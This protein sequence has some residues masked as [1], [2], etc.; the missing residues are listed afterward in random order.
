MKNKPFF[1]KIILT[2]SCIV[3]FLLM[4]LVSFVMLRTKL[5]ES[6]RLRNLQV[7]NF[8][9]NMEQWEKEF[10]NL[11]NMA[12]SIRILPSFDRFAL[13]HSDDYF[14][15]LTNLYTEFNRFNRIITSANY[16]VFVHK[17]NDNT[18]ITNNGTR[19]LEMVLRDL[20]LS[21]GSYEE[22]IK[23][24]TSERLYQ[25]S[26]FISDHTLL[27]VYVV[28][29]IDTQM[30]ISIHIPMSKISEGSSLTEPE[31]ELVINDPK[32]IDLREEKSPK[33]K[34]SDLNS[35]QI[36]IHKPIIQKIDG[37]EYA[38]AASSYINLYYIM[39]LHM[40][41]LEEGI[42][43]ILQIAFAFIVICGISY[44]I[45]R[46]F[47]VKL[48]QPIEKLINS[49]LEF[50]TVNESTK[51][52]N[53]IEFMMRQVTRIRENNQELAQ[54]LEANITFS[55]NHFLKQL[56]L[57]KLSAE[58]MQITSIKPNLDWIEEPLCV[59]LFEFADVEKLNPQSIDPTTN[60]F[61]HLLTE[62]IQDD[63]QYH[64]V[65]MNT[66]TI[67]FLVHTVDIDFLRNL[68]N[69][70]L[71]V[72][73][74][75]FH[76]SA[77]IYI[78]PPCYAMSEISHAYF[79]VNRLRNYRKQLPMKNIY[80]EEDIKHLP[81]ER[82]IYPLSLENNILEAVSNGDSDEIS[83]I[84]DTIFKNYINTYFENLELRDMSIFAL[85]NTI[86]RALEYT[87]ISTPIL[88]KQEKSLFLELRCCISAS[89]LK[90]CVQ[91]HFLDIISIVNNSTEKKQNDLHEALQCYIEENYQR[92]LSLLDI[93]EHFLLSPTYMSVVFKNTMGDNFKDYLSRIR[94]EHAVELLKDNPNIK[95]ISLGEH[96]GISNVNTLIRIFKK[97]SGLT[98]GQYTRKHIT[99][100]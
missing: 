99:T 84:L 72:I 18:V 49:I 56:L 63:I 98:P 90:E 16:S 96:V 51:N 10:S 23:K 58:E 95:L 4:L 52:E 73:D 87:A 35:M 61:V 3:G 42:T 76:L 11:F 1:K 100:L 28:D 78:S 66:S 60:D 7:K 45:I 82:A 19:Q 40:G 67:C 83:R 12:Q 81:V 20:N 59:V 36:Q 57:G 43:F 13:C 2:Y 33:L 30:I 85:T 46:F 8:T 32:F 26:Y 62:S 17:L 27:Y 69:K 25:E 14:I 24:A 34:P 79:T 47:S 92:D 38:L 5:S 68:L 37:K 74:T 21:P 64:Y 65:P 22:I 50:S 15:E 48:Y 80:D 44:T 89:E 53:E 93:A 6:Q 75:A 70:T 77:F 97:H 91:K 31:F 94:F 55:Q 29:Y 39:P 88:A 9:N 54:R 86:N 41:I 71:I